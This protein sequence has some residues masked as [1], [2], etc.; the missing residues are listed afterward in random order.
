[1]VRTRLPEYSFLPLPLREGAW[2]AAQRRASFLPLPLR[3]GVGGRGRSFANFSVR[4]ICSDGDCL[5]HSFQVVGHV[6]VPEPNYAQALALHPRIAPDISPA[7]N[8][9]GAVELD[10]QARGWTKEVRNIGAD[11]DLSAKLETVPQ[12]LLRASAVLPHYSSED[13]QPLPLCDPSP[14]PPPARGGGVIFDAALHSEILLKNGFQM[15][16]SGTACLAVYPRWLQ[17]A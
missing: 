8:M 1:M 11:R 3:E 4:A 15:H 16:E 17:P 14:Q 5:K 2:R 9:S 13:K 6:V 12:H 10:Y 7:I